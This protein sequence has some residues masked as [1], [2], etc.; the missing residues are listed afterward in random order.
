MHSLSAH[1]APV[2]RRARAQ[3]LAGVRCAL[4]DAQQQGA[5]LCHFARLPHAVVLLILSLLPV[6]TRLRCAE[7]C[8]SWRTAATERS[9]WLRLDL[10]PESGIARRRITDALLR[11]AAARAGGALLS[12][13]V[14][15]CDYIPP[16]ALLAVAMENA[17]TLQEAR[18]CLGAWP[19]LS[20]EQLEALLR[21]APRLRT[22][23]AEMQ[24]TAAESRRF[25]R[26]EPPFEALR[27]TASL[28]VARPKRLLQT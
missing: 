3:R 11:A 4:L 27:V 1:H 2:G 20:C 14:T 8:R 19:G 10:S 26:N 18:L 25:L 13:A 28:R 23:H 5:P 24:C 9:L 15:D 17:A 16:P 12:L 6:D 22:L 7:V 21:G